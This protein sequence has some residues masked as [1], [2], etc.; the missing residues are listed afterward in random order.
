MSSSKADPRDESKV[1]AFHLPKAA[2]ANDWT[3]NVA[4]YSCKCIPFALHPPKSS[5]FTS[6]LVLIDLALGGMFLRVSYTISKTSVEI[7]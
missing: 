7:H 6:I 4:M 3:G 1:V 5:I 2:E